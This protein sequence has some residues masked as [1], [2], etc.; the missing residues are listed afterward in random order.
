[1]S[2]ARNPSPR[3]PAVPGAAADADLAPEAGATVELKVAPGLERKRAC[4]PSGRWLDRLLQWPVLV[5]PPVNMIVGGLMNLILSL[6]AQ[7]RTNKD[8]ATS[9]KIRDELGQLKIQVKDGKDGAS[10]TIE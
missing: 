1:M 6:R 7:A 10:W 8:F 9:D 3:R 2:A 5:Y 4:R